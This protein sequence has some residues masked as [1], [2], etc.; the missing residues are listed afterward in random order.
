MNITYLAISYTVQYIRDNRDT[1]E[2]FC[3][4]EDATEIISKQEDAT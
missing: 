2:T 1:T 3:R 4:Q